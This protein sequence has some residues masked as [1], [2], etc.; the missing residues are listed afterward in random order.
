M[1]LEDTIEVGRGAEGS[2]EK[3]S[4]INHESS[5]PIKKKPVNICY[6]IPKHPF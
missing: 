5:E 4:K 2:H 6:N 1:G 3:P